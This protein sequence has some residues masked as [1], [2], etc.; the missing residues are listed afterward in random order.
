MAFDLQTFDAIAFDFATI[1]ANYLS[2]SL[3][4]GAVACIDNDISEWYESGAMPS[5]E[6][7]REVDA[8]YGNED[9]K[10]AETAATFLL[11]VRVA[12]RY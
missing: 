3:L 2:A 7:F 5:E 12:V 10:D 4:A 6:V 9:P 11:L 1:E 8:F